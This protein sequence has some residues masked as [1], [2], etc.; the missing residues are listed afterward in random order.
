MRSIW[1]LCAVGV[2]GINFGVSLTCFAIYS[3]YEFQ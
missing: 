3:L 2:I 1:R